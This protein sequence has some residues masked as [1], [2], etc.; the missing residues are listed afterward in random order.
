MLK[1]IAHRRLSQKN[2]ERRVVRHRN[3][4]C[5]QTKFFVE[6]IVIWDQ[7]VN[8][9]LQ[10]SRLNEHS[11][12]SICRAASISPWRGLRDHHNELVQTSGWSLCHACPGRIRVTS[13]EAAAVNASL[14]LCLDH[15]RANHISSV[16]PRQKNDGRGVPRVS[17]LYL[18][19]QHK[20][21]P[22]YETANA[23]LV[24]EDGSRDRVLNIV[25]W[26]A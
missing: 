3:G 26:S 21:V 23:F 2:A 18:W 14:S 17:L 13:L 20:P 5:T 22:Q 16:S 4:S 6:I 15:L 1:K 7:Y 12:I 8:G 24:L 11:P 19:L 25:E 9:R 10:A